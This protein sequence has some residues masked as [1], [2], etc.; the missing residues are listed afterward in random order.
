MSSTTYIRNSEVKAN[1][2]C[3][4]CSISLLLDD[5]EEEFFLGTFSDDDRTPSLRHVDE[6]ASGA[7]AGSPRIWDDALPDLPAMSETAQEGCRI[8]RFLS[9][10]LLRKQINFQGPVKVCARYVWGLDRDMMV[11][12]DDGLVNWECI[13]YDG[14]EE[15]CSIDFNIETEIDEI[16]TWLRM[17]KKRRPKPLDPI[18]VK[19]MTHQIRQCDEGCDHIKSDQF[20][21]TRLVNVGAQDEDS[22][23][24][25]I[26]ADLIKTKGSGENH[27]IKY[28]ALS[29]CWGPEEDAKQ[30]VKTTKDNIS[31]H[32]EAMTLTE[33]SP[34]VKDAILVCRALGIQY[35]WIDALCI[36]QGDS[37]DWDKENKS[38]SR[39][40]GSILCKNLDE[41]QSSWTSRGWAF[42]E[43]ILSLRILFFGTSMCHFFCRFLIRPPPFNSDLALER[44]KVYDRWSLA[45][46]I[47]RRKWTYRD[48]FLPSLSGLAKGYANVINDVYLAGLWKNNLQ[49]E[50]T[51]GVLW[52]DPGDL[53]DTLQRNRHQRPYVAPS[54]SWASQEKA[55]ERSV[56]FSSGRGIEDTNNTRSKFWQG[57]T[58]MCHL[59]FEFS[60]KD[61]AMDL[62][63]ENLFGRLKGGFIQVSG[64]VVPFPS[65]VL[66]RSRSSSGRSEFGYFVN[67]LGTCEFDWASQPN[68]VQ[69]LGK[70]RLL[71]TSSCCASTSNW[72]HILWRANSED[73]PEELQRNFMESNSMCRVLDTDWV[74]SEDYEPGSYYRVGI[75]LLP[76]YSGGSNLFE[77]IENEIIKLI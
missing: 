57:E 61:V 37:K 32:L 7:T 63:G 16:S 58:R 15:L 13:V 44:S 41:G 22:A 29:Y 49:Y 77:G 52:P 47:L 55:V 30:Q 48:D 65:E 62:W 64:K 67:G 51:W 9:Q 18:N 34:V 28:A 68:T 50:L 21:P 26:T 74:K 36:L 5:S 69:Q 66:I 25:V 17:D 40:Y 11:V 59:R 42:Q 46:G 53:S 31:S 3:D 54:W 75:F 1:S 10:A 43:S 33:T 70:M 38:R 2:L 14:E 56:D 27:G 19:W 71:P 35:L 20:L 12:R 8:C 4:D 45:R 73:N 76:A 39:C 6:N 24:L 60:L 72:K 23:R